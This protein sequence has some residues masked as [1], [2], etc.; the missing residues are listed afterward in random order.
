MK[1]WYKTWRGLIGEALEK[2]DESWPD[3]VA[4]TLDAQGLDKGFDAGS[5]SADSESFTA[6]T[7]NYVYFPVTH[8]GYEW[9][10]STPR[11]PNG[12]ATE[13]VGG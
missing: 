5:G 11:N 3:V 9:A 6:W 8:D 1:E 4:C 12:E 2:R 7:E 10:D 13:H